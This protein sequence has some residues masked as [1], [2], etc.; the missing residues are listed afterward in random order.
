[1]K[2][3]VPNTPDQVQDAVQWAFE[4]ATPLN[5][6]GL[7]TKSGLGR[8]VTTDHMLCLS[9]LSGITLYEPEELVMKAMAGTPLAEIETALAEKGQRLA[10]EPPNL[11]AL[12]GSNDSGTIGGI[13]ACNLSGPRRVWGGAARDHILGVSLV[14]GR[15]ELVKSGGRVVKNVTGFDLPKL[16]AGSFGTLGAITEVAFK[17][18]PKGERER[19]VLL[20]GAGVGEAEEALNLAMRGPFEM[21][22]AAY[23]PASIAARIGHSRSLVALRFEGP[24]PSVDAKTTAL[25]CLLGA[26]GEVRSID[27]DESGDFW[28]SIRDVAVFANDREK[29]IWRLSVPPANAAAVVSRL[30]EELNAEWFWDRAGGLIW[31]A[32]P[33]RRQADQEL[34]RAAIGPGGGHATLIRA[35]EEVRST[36]DVFHPQ[37]KPVAALSKRIKAAFDPSFIL[38]PGRMYGEA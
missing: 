9:G 4:T 38:S 8:P 28:Q 13:F 23:L 25:R 30:P 32:I 3:L 26:F 16:L 7:G 6:Q 37:P 1:M 11:A 19:T 12:F 24:G 10:F 35:A 15:G 5:L 18:L 29:Q 2:T 36:I 14:N 20:R 22:G 31:L 21:S 33:P 17:V 34:V 27:Q